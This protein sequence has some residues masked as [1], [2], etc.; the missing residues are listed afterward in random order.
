MNARPSARGAAFT[1][2]EYDTLCRGAGVN[3]YGY[4]GLPEKTFDQL[5]KFIL[6]TPTAGD[7]LDDPSML[8]ALGSRPGAGRTITAR[9]YVGMIALPDGS[10][11]EILPKLYDRRA[12]NPEQSA[13][14]ARRTFLHM[15]RT[16]GDIPSKVS[17]QT[18]L[19]TSRGTLLDIFIRMFA[20]EALLLVKRGLKSDYREHEDNERFYKGKL[21]VSAHIRHN[22]VHR[23]RFYIRYDEFGID[24]P[25]NRL[26]KTTLERLIRLTGSSRIQKELRMLLDAFDTVPSCADPAREWDK[27]SMD[28][29]MQEYRTVLDW[30]RIFLDSRSFTPL[31]GAD[32]AYALLF[33]MERI[34]ERY[35]ALLLKRRFAES[36]V[37][38]STQ[39]TA[40]KLFEEP[41]R[42]PLR[43]DIVLRG[44]PSGT[45]VMDTKWKMLS[46]RYGRDYGISQS[47]MYQMYAYGKKYGAKKV[48]LLYPRANSEDSF[49]TP[50]EYDSGDGVKVEVML[51][52]LELGEQCVDEAIHSIL[53]A[54]S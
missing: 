32:R 21:Q 7:P 45:I 23:E 43:P 31:G 46:R 48:V 2:R 52:D 6:E 39:D 10:V 40:H 49:K 19:G 26:I 50:V 22:A 25:E 30:C 16:I 37:Q 12:E 11:V 17:R 42:F 29:N 34:F 53:L 14:R 15:L 13:E 27:V 44:T 41:A 5:E 4:V 47:D 20:E 1:L 54:E 33:P 28:R 38:V 36:S 24:R 35:V 3:A 8:L 18:G 9:N 51:L